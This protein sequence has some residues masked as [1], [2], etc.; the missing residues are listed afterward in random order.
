MRAQQGNGHQQNMQ[1]PQ[2]KELV[3]VPREERVQRSL[4][5]VWLWE[6][7]LPPA[8]KDRMTDKIYF[9]S[10]IK[11]DKGVQY[12][13]PCPIHSKLQGNVSGRLFDVPSLSQLTSTDVS[14]GPGAG[15]LHKATPGSPRHGPRGKGRRLTHLSA[16]L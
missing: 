5:V 2:G 6:L 8:L 9:T 14:G 7:T 4:A 15:R 16:C 12:S 13:A 1:P 11:I 3:G 10:R